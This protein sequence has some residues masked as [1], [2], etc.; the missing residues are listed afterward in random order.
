[1]FF[2][3]RKPL[4]GKKRE[5]PEGL[6]IK[7]DKCGELI[8]KAQLEKNNHVCPHCGYHF[9]VGISV[10]KRV[11]LDGGEFEE[12]IAPNLE[13]EDPLN[14]PGYKEKI[15]ASKEKTGLNEAAVA[16]VARIDGKKV[17]V[18]MTDFFFMGGS[19]GSV[20]GEKF[21]R[22][23]RKAVELKVPLISVT[24]SGGGARMH[25]GAISLM[26]MAKTTVGVLEV[27]EAGLPFINILLDP[28]MGGVMA[29]F[30]SQG[31]I[32]LAEPGALLGFAGPRVIRE[33][34]REELPP[35]FQRS[36]F[37][38]EHGFIDKIVKRGE[39]K[40]TVSKIL[41]YIYYKNG[42]G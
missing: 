28:T 16:G 15:L 32:I 34:I 33:T 8:Y 23:A 27:K 11:L 21:L 31:D 13:S 7:C 12:E 6:W 3:I 30:A 4:D 35:S 10:M 26:Q 18:F 19:M 22:A 37:Q 36:E 1:M 20:V 42:K 2:K 17:V 40:E 25:E 5:P 39:M 24:S 9:R 41:T 38:L 14:F 29:S